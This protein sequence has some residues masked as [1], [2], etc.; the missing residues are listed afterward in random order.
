MSMP[1]AFKVG[2]VD[3]G[4]VTPLYFNLLYIKHHL[5]LQPSNT[6]TGLDLRSHY[7]CLFINTKLYL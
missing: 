3:A 5:L 6:D 4:G 2:M 1:G 7:K